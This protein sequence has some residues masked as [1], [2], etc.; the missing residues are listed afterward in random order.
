MNR[1]L[2]K[3]INFGGSI[4]IAVYPV[5]VSLGQLDK[6]GVDDLSVYIRPRSSRRN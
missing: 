3:I 5:R 1:I 6:E 4:T 2:K